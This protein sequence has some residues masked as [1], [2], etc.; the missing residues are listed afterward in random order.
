MKDKI[1]EIKKLLLDD[2]E[3]MYLKAELE[4]KRQEEAEMAYGVINDLIIG[5]DLDLEKITKNASKKGRGGSRKKVPPK[6]INKV[7]GKTWTGRGRRPVD[8]DSGDWEPIE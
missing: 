1:E 3:Y 5:L 2:S 8:F 6:Y 4:K 7:N